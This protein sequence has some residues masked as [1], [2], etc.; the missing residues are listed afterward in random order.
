MSFLAPQTFATVLFGLMRMTESARQNY[1]TAQIQKTDIQII[2]PKIKSYIETIPPEWRSHAINRWAADQMR[3]LGWTDPG[4]QAEGIVSVTSGGTPVIAEGREAEFESLKAAMAAAY[5]EQSGVDRARVQAGLIAWNQEDWLKGQGATPWSLFAR[6][7]LDIG[8]D[9][10]AV[11]PG[12]AGGGRSIR[13]LIA[14]MAPHLAA[15]YTPDA[16]GQTPGKRLAEVFA[17]TALNTLAERPDLL[18]R[19]LRWQR[20]ISGVLMPLQDE[21]KTSGASAL[22]AEDRIRDLMEGPMSRSVLKLIDENSDDYFKGAAG[23]GKLGGIV[24]RST[25]GELATTSAEGRSLRQTFSQIGVD[26]LVNS[27]LKAAAERPELFIRSGKGSEPD[28]EIELGRKFLTEYAGILRAA[29]RPFRLADGMGEAVISVSLEVTASNLA[30]RIERAAGDAPQNQMGAALGAYLVRDIFQGFREAAAP[31]A[32]G[33]PLARLGPEKAVDLLRIVAEH[34]ARAPH[35]V[36]GKTANPAV[37]GLARSVA[38]IIASD[39]TGLMSAEDWRLV[40]GATLQAALENPGTLFGKSPAGDMAR[41]LTARVLDTARKNFT[42]PADQPGRILFGATLRDALIVTL[43]AA[44]TGVLNTFSS[45]EALETHLNGVDA[46]AARLNALAVSQDRTLRIGSRD[47]IRI[48]TF[49]IARALEGGELA[50]RNLSDTD[51]VQV[52]R[53]Q[54]M[55]GLEEGAG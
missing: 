44:S 18:S 19:E 9:L 52:I 31:G 53:L 30:E 26:S 8:L 3:R 12:L 14:A 1:I 38:E 2:L 55:R 25:L 17:Q 15:A 13:P 27:T 7:L 21:V 28:A 32:A 41:V 51:L 23:A 49:Y 50:I 10:L 36:V 33:A 48:Y 34:V 39:E 42:L 29:P 35:F 46:L 22:L 16:Q 24:L 6:H 45:R 47:W 43:D 20:L 40:I 4:G 5:I 54:P 37:S 11:N